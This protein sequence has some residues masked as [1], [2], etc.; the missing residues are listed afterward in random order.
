MI[1]TPRPTARSEMVT[2]SVSPERC[3][4]MTPSCPTARAAQPG[5]TRC[6]P[7]WLILSSRPLH[8]FFS[9]AVLM[10]SGLV[11]V[12]SSPMMV[13]PAWARRGDHASSRPGRRG[14]QSR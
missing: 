4:T 2:S 10:R 3:E 13:M 5:S 14:P 12:K 6:G 7:I 8:A 1:P 9:M 11:T